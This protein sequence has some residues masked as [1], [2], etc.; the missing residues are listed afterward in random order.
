M[1]SE[2]TVIVYAREYVDGGLKHY[3]EITTEL[4]QGLSLEDKTKAITSF[5]NEVDRLLSE[6]REKHTQT[7]IVTTKMI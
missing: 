7:D 4:I 1:N 2:K 6:H 3:A 5:L